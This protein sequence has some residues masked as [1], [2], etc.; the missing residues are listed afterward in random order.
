MSSNIKVQ[1]ICKHCNA[2][3][4]AKTTKTKY[5]SHKCNKSAYKAKKRAEKISTSN[6]EVLQIKK[7][8]IEDVKAKE[9]LTAKDTAT[10]LGFSL[11]TVYRLIDNGTIEAVNLGERLTRIK[12]SSLYQLLEQ[13]KP[14]LSLNKTL[15]VDISECYNIGEVQQKFNI[16]EKTLFDLIKREQIPKIKK[17]KFTYIPKQLIENLLT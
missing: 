3:F 5:C 10:L 14:V 13:P 1:R 2:E 8:P 17:G 16:S 11:R 6:K 12:L 7:Q 9:F 15:E 4:T